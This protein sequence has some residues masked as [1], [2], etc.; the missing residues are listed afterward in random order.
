MQETAQSS[1]FTLQVLDPFGQTA[2]IVKTVEDPTDVARQLDRIQERFSFLEYPIGVTLISETGEFLSIGLAGEAWMLI[3]TRVAD[4]EPEEQLSSL[5]SDAGG[6]IRFYF[7]QLDEFP[8]RFLIPK[9]TAL[10]AITLW[11]NDG[12]LSSRCR[13]TDDLDM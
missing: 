13:W 11:M 7:G 8:V 3:L 9:E 12:S 5:G 2:P 4:G 1:R 10:E 6:T